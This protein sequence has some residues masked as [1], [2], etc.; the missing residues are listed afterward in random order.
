MSDYSYG[1]GRLGPLL[2]GEGVIN[3]GTACPL[4]ARAG[5]RTLDRRT[6]TLRHL[7]SDRDPSPRLFCRT[8][9]W[10]TADEV[11]S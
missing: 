4:C 11:A 7:E 5:R 6:P 1:P 10:L 8:H 3:T 2:D 9:G